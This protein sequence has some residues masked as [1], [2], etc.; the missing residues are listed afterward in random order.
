VDAAT[1]A[2]NLQAALTDSVETLAS[3]SLTAASAVAAGNNF[4]NGTPQ[5][6]A[7]PPFDTATAL[8]A[9][10][11]ANTVTWYTGENGATPARATAIA[12]VDTAISASYG[13]R[14]NEEGIRWVIQ[15][16]AVLAA[17]TY[18]ST[19]PDAAARASALSSRIATNLQVPPGT[20]KI[21]D[22]STEL[23][24]VQSTIRS[25]ADRHTQTKS[26]LAG[27]LDTIEGVKNEEV[28]AQIMALQTRLQASLQTT[29]LLL[30]TSL[31]NYL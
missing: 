4:F 3:T 16:V 17:V 12:R 9:G 11:S 21:E 7:G 30:N 23:A 24:G 19:D 20:Q 13:M 15:N 31:V 25:A 14:A 1:T 8:V 2:A 6:V 22:I 27:L 29:S 10:T 5:R 28:A 26:A 18:S